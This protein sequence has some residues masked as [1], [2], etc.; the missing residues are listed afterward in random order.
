MA[1]AWWLT[2]NLAL[3]TVTDPQELARPRK[4]P[5]SKPERALR[6]HPEASAEA[7]QRPHLPRTEGQLG[8]EPQPSPPAGPIHLGDRHPGLPWF[9]EALSL[10]G[11]PGSPC[12]ILLAFQAAEVSGREGRCHCPA[13]WVLTSLIQPVSDMSLFLCLC[14]SLSPLVL[15][16]YA[17]A[18]VFHPG[19]SISLFQSLYQS[20]M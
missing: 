10:R 20:F 16:C 13:L 17:P 8:W 18:C 15:S 2:P 4:D 7:R 3:S 14:H 11:V 19:P 1:C 9:R 5:N 6:Q 12:C